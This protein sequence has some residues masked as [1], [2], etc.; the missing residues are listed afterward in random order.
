MC[1]SSAHRR[2]EFCSSSVSFDYHHNS[3]RCK[4]KT[5]LFINSHT[6]KTPPQWS[7]QVR[8]VAQKHQVEPVLVKM[9]MFPAARPPHLLKQRS[10]LHQG[11]TERLACGGADGEATCTAPRVGCMDIDGPRRGP[12]Q[13]TWDRASTAYIH[14][15]KADNGP[16]VA[17]LRGDSNVKGQVTF[18]QD[19]ESGPT[20]I[21]YDITGND[22]NAERG[23]HVHVS[24]QRRHGTTTAADN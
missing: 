15:A 4:T 21:T 8:S 18:E 2:L 6:T 17:V 14:D 16:T 20:K 13:W 9:S 7:K 10:S 3:N 1:P 19:S 12:W 22:A 11:L 24:V 5:N 23:M